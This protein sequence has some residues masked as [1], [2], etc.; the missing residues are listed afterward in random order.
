MKYKY[1]QLTNGY[2]TLDSDISKTSMS[3]CWKYFFFL[4]TEYSIV[5][6]KFLGWGIYSSSPPPPPTPHSYVIYTLVCVKH[7]I[8]YTN[9]LPICRNGGWFSREWHQRAWG[10]RKS[11]SCGIFQKSVNRHECQHPSDTNEPY[12]IHGHWKTSSTRCQSCG[13]PGRRR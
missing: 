9:Y 10:R 2:I 8:K 3:L 13:R 1:L 12:P 7:L 11:S 4:C 6:S 5:I